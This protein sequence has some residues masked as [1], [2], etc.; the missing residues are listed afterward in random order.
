L[1]VS[2]LKITIFAHMKIAITGTK[3]IP[4]RYGGFEQFADQLSVR[5]A[6]R[7]HH[8]WVYNPRFHPYRENIYHKVHIILKWC[9]ENLLGPGA[10]YLY[11][12]ICLQD[13]VRRKANIVLQCGYA[14]AVPA[15]RMI[16][17][18]KTI[19]ITH[20]DGMEWQR[21]KWNKL[22]QFLIRKAEKT[23]VK[24]SPVLVC[25]HPEIQE[26]YK[27]HHGIEPVYIP[28]GAEIFCNPD[29]KVLSQFH[30][31]PFEYCLIIARLEP[32]N[33]IHTIINGFLKSGIKEKLIIIG[34]RNTKYGHNLLHHYDN[35][36]RI[37]F[38]ENIY[39]QT[40]LNNLRHFSKVYFHGHSVGGTNPSLLEALAAGSFI[41]AHDNK[42]NRYIL[43]DNALYFHNEEDIQRI[44]SSEP[45]WCSQKKKMIRANIKVI[46]ENYQWNHITDQYENLFKQLMNI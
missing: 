8:V 32:E 42:F 24:R 12:Y 31:N 28:Y 22:T 10:N 30:I 45:D 4:N 26:Y 3:G 16:N 7:G 27:T 14:S 44:L 33:K 17:F 13:A 2:G 20:L 34:D 5:L 43:K 11:D 15:Y 41:I 9:P 46:Q 40:I 19:L 36:S 21:T 6:E 35:H 1:S 23:A 39:D 38:I 18:M 37:I 25:D 29:K